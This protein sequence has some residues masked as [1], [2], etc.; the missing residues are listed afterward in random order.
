MPKDCFSWTVICA[1][2]SLNFTSFCKDLNKAIVDENIEN[3]RG[4]W[5]RKPDS[6]NLF[7][8]H[9]GN[10]NNSGYNWS[11]VPYA[12]VAKM[13]KNLASWTKCWKKKSTKIELENDNQLETSYTQV[14]VHLYETPTAPLW[15]KH[16][17]VLH[18][19]IFK[20]TVS[21]WELVSVEPGSRFLYTTKMLVSQTNP[22]TLEFTVLM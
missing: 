10:I 20:W 3:K 15:S 8:K 14:Y 21:V 6:E 19:Y 11:S 18:C 17:L 9:Y 1:A 4:D 13:A 12:I 2:F 5:N 7:T 16:C 22:N